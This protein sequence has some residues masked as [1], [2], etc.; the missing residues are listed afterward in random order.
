MDIA[1]WE[2]TTNS[3]NQVLYGVSFKS[4]EE[5]THVC[6]F[7]LTVFLPNTQVTKG[8]STLLMFL[9]TM[10]SFLE[11]HNLFSILSSIKTNSS[12]LIL[13]F[14]SLKLSWDIVYT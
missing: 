8:T 1:V 5:Q 10:R 2:A 7:I 12:G 13:N 6:S 14:M 11:C 9:W 4:I 3:I